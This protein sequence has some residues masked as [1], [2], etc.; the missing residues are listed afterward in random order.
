VLAPAAPRQP[1]EG[2]EEGRGGVVMER[3]GADS[4]ASRMRERREIPKIE[5]GEAGAH[6]GGRDGGV[7]GA[8]TVLIAHSFWGWGKGWGS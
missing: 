6:F 5:G 3:G 4:W 7:A 1:G 2:A 8:A